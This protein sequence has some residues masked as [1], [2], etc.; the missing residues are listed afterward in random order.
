MSK[1]NIS[2]KK[3]KLPP[4]SEALAALIVQIFDDIP[5]PGDDNLVIIQGECDLE[6]QEIFD[7][8]V[9]KHWKTLSR[10]TLDYNHQSLFFFTPAAYRFYLP[11]Y[12][13]A[14]VLSYNKAGNIPGS[15]IVSLTPPEEPGDEMDSFLAKMGGFNA[16]QKAAIFSFLDFFVVEHSEDFPA[17]N[18]ESVLDRYWLQFK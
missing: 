4:K 5:Y 8:F 2:K 16:D 13:K 10:R 14:C 6:R 9:G 17:Y 11:A 1:K 18:L 3:S 12:L 7:T 15:V